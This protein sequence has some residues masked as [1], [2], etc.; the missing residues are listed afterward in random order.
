M[1]NGAGGGVGTFATQLAKLSGAHVTGVDVAQKL[2]TVRDVGADLVIDYAQQDFTSNGDTYDLIVDCQGTRPMSSIKPALK[3]GATYAVVGA[4]MIRV[5]QMWLQS[6]FDKFTREARR[7]RLVA[8]GRNKG[9]ADLASLLEAGQ[10]VPVIDRT[11]RLEEVP[12]ALAYFGTGQ[13]K[14]KIAVTIGQ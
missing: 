8:E 12:E 5:Y 6:A 9:L 10:I 3:P 7:L 11:C 13:H 2:D 14:G 1:I 4:Q